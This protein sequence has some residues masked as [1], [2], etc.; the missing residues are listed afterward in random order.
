MRPLLITPNRA[1][2]RRL[3]VRRLSLEDLARS[4]LLAQGVEVAS[5][6]RARR[7]LVQAVRETVGPSDPEG[8]AAAISPALRALLRAGDREVLEQALRKLGESGPDKRAERVVRVALAYLE[9]LEKKGFVDPASLL[10]RAGQVVGKAKQFL[11][12]EGYPYLGAG[13]RFFLQRVAA[14]GSTVT[15]PLPSGPMGEANQQAKELLEKGG[16]EVVEAPL[17]PLAQ[18]FLEAKREVPPGVQVQ[19]LR[20]PDREQEVRYIL[21]RIKNLL[22]QGVPAERIALVVRDDRLYGPLAAVVVLEQGIPLRLLYRIPVGETRVGSLLALLSQALSGFPYEATLRLLFHPLFPL[23]R[24]LDLRQART[25]RPQ[26]EVA[27]KGLGLPEALC[28]IS[29]MAKGRELVQALRG[30][31]SPLRGRLRSWP[32]ERAALE[33]V[34]RGL[35]ELTEEEKEGFF[36]GLSELLFHLTVPTQPG[37]RGLELNTP[38]ARYGGSYRYLFVLGMAEGLAPA[39][40]TEDP[41]L[42]FPE[43][44]RLRDLGLSLEEPWEE[45]TRE[46]LVFAALLGSVEEGGQVVLAYPEVVGQDPVP[47]SPY[48]ARLGLEPEPPKERLLGSRVEARRLGRWEGDP[49]AEQMKRALAAERERQGSKATPYNGQAGAPFHPP[50]LSVNA[51]E[52]LLLCP[53]RFFLRYVLRP[54]GAEEAEDGE[55][56]KEGEFLHAVLATLFWQAKAAGKTRGAEIRSWALQEGGLEK[57]FAEVETQWRSEAHFLR[58]R[59]WPH[60]RSHLLLALALALQKPNFLKDDA[61]VQAVEREVKGSTPEL[62]DIVI[63][64]RIDRWDNRSGSTFLVDYKRT[65]HGV[66]EVPLGNGLR[67][68]LQIPLYLRLVN[69]GRGQGIYYG[70]LDGKLIHSPRTGKGYPPNREEVLSDLLARAGTLL[71]KGTFPA[72][73]GEMTQVCRGCWAKSVCRKEVRA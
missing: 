1:V 58:C 65:S 31:L 13:E 22:A 32:R 64:G 50:K 38:L 17:S 28:E 63:T 51:L 6:F 49:L 7:L 37:Y 68:D 45:A 20:F 24:S 53:F 70:L 21:A 66:K 40:V 57:A 26:G 62:K 48:L 25:L 59:D 4:L 35:P 56:G 33:A 34:L 71:E 12:V 18:A 5:P 2:A 61:E 54:Q 72:A 44:Q 69:E 10:V 47:P 11:R 41:L 67:M 52:E 16:L 60:R 39:P 36:S 19:A 9:L 23:E 15:L 43:R 29:R 73:P 27:W 8:F 14:P 55:L 3:K 46:A 42:G 30:F